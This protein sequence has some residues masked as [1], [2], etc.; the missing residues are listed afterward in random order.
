[1]ASRLDRLLHSSRCTNQKILSIELP[2]VVQ[3]ARSLAVLFPSYCEISTN[4]FIV[5]IIYFGYHNY[6]D[7]CHRDKSF[8]FVYFQSSLAAHV[9]LSTKIAP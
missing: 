4:T 3:D 9:L 2:I 8:F 7:D 5:I 6:F 1:M